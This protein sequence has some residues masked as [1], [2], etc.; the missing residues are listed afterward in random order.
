MEK[1]S[2]NTLR[3][4][5]AER[6]ADHWSVLCSMQKQDSCMCVSILD[7]HLGTNLLQSAFL[8]KNVKE[9]VLG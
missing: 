4:K 7:I 5:A 9:T 3:T 1:W 2:R 6:V 8:N